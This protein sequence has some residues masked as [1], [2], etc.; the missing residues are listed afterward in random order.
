MNEQKRM[1]KLM[2]AL[3]GIVGATAISAHA[4]GEQSISVAVANS[5]KIQQVMTLADSM[6]VDYTIRPKLSANGQFEA[7]VIE[8]S[9]SD[10]VSYAALRNM[11]A[12]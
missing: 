9:V 7:G 6:G 12:N 1:N 5:Q 11:M 2:L 8:I 3:V 4:S 10:R